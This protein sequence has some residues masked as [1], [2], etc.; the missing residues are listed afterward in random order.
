MLIN[1]A[2]ILEGDEII[3]SS[4]SKLKYLKVLK[5]GTA[6]HK[7]S[8]QKGVYEEL[9]TYWNGQP[10]VSKRPIMCEPDISKHTGVFYLK[11]EDGYRDMWLVKRV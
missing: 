10:Y 11:D 3:I 9:T 4:N 2:D 6:S 7:C 5:L 8:F 1:F